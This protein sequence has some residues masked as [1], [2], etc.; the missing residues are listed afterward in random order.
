MQSDKLQNYF[1]LFGI[2]PTFRIDEQ[3][4]EAVYLK[5]Q[6]ALHPDRYATA[7][8]QERRI[9]AQKSAYL[10]EAY[11]VLTDTCN[12][13]DY[14]LT[15]QGHTSNP[16]ASMSDN[17]FLMQQ[18]EFRER[19]EDTVAEQS[20]EQAATLCAEIDR[21]S[22]K[23]DKDFERAYDEH[24]YDVAQSLVAQMRFMKKLKAEAASIAA[25]NENL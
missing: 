3:T 25:T 21:C 6:A 10:N 24:K 8:T 5:L 2:K 9:A 23:I 19:L 20:R 13:A 15:M 16:D 17:G 22:D 1:E 7:S 18:M 11:A 14:L 4:I 12:R